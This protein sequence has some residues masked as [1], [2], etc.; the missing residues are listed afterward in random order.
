MAAGNI[1]SFVLGRAFGDVGNAFAG[2]DHE[3][4]SRRRFAERQVWRF[5]LGLGR[6]LPVRQKRRAAEQTNN[7]SIS[8][9]RKAIDAVTN[10]RGQVVSRVNADAST[11]NDDPA[12]VPF[13]PFGRDR[14]SPQ[15]KAHPTP[16]G[17]Q[18]TSIRAKTSLRPTMQGDLFE[19]PAGA[20]QLAS[21]VEYRSRNYRAMPIRCRRAT[22]CCREMLRGST[23]TTV[24][25]CPVKAR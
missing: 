13:N 8:R 23:R 3:D 10:A 2:V 21:G 16:D 14:F 12:C 17:F 15:A 9:M 7:V 19:L 4:L 25:G 24:R 6:L 11:A 18:T 20:V 1:P 5:E 22:R